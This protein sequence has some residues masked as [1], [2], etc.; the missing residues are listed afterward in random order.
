MTEHDY[1][2]VGAGSAGCVL[3]N[4]LS[5]DPSVRVR[6][7]E[8]GGATVTRTSASRRRS[9]SSSTPKLDWDYATEPEP[10]VNGRSLFI[11]RGKSVGGS[12]SMNAMLYVRGRPLD[13]DLWVEQGAAGLG[14]ERRPAVLHALRGQRPRRRRSS[15]APGASCGSRSSARRAPSTRQLIE[16]SAAAGIPRIDDYN[17]PEQDGVSMF[18]VTQRDG[19]RWSAA[20]AFLRPALGRPN[21][22][23]VTGATVLGLELEGGRAAGVRYAKGRGSPQVA[24]GDGAR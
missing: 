20:D 4:R 8:A 22:E 10:A 17:G 24:C 23:V 1:V 11:P 9:R 21:L 19:G 5:E 6:V 7:I 3:A 16:A 12:S 13:Y 15:T 18:Q 2:I 14:L